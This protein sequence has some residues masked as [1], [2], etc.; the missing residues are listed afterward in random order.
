LNAEGA[1][2]NVGAQPSL[3]DVQIALITGVS[4]LF[5]RLTLSALILGAGFPAFAADFPFEG[6]WKITKAIVAPWED[7]AHPMVTDD[8]ERYTDKVVEITR[9]ALKGPDLLGCGKTGIEIKSMPFAGL[10]EGGLAADP[11]D[12]GGKYDEAK[13]KTLAL[14]LG[15]TAEPVPSLFHGCSEIILHKR[16]GK[17]LLF[18][19][20]NR[21][22]TLDKQ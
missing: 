2:I 3:I 13:A 4:M 6:S 16:D 20:N 18:G 5:R 17:T 8:A 22:F 21:I 7:P 11:K 15:F 10:F 1:A 12:P 9:D 14:E 19:L